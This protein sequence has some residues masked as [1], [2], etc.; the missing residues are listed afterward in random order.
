MR[1]TWRKHYEGR[2]TEDKLIGGVNQIRPIKNAGGHIPTKDEV[3]FGLMQPCT[4]NIVDLELDVRW[5]KCGHVGAKVVSNYLGNEGTPHCQ[6][7][8]PNET[9]LDTT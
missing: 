1:Q 4:F 7:R 2:K 3:K 6:Y 8:G 5:Y 9:D